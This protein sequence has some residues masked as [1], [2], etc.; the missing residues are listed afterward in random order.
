MV[1]K[2]QLFYIYNVILD[3]S[4]QSY[5]PC[6]NDD[7]VQFF[8]LYLTVF[9]SKSKAAGSETVSVH[10][11][12]VVLFTYLTYACE[13]L[14]FTKSDI[15]PLDNLIV[16]SLCSIVNVYT[17]ENIDCLRHYLNVPCLSVVFESRK[18]RLMD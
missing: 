11:L 7:F 3:K 9:F 16:R 2:L 15:Y 4:M 13:A 6:G 14:P 10:L 8:F 5:L 18:Q 12:Q 17:R 1:D